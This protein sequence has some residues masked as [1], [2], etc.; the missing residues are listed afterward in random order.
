MDLIANCSW[1]IV[2]PDW[3]SVEPSSGTGSVSVILRAESN[4]GRERSG[5]LTVTGGDA[6]TEVALYQDGVDFSVDQK[7]F[8]F[9]SD[10]NPMEFT[11]ISKYDWSITMHNEA[12]WVTADP[13]SGNAGETRVRLTPSPITDRTPRNRTYLTVNYNKSF[14]NL[15]VSQD[16]PNFPPAAPELIAPAMGDTDVKINA[17][18]SWNASADPD[19]DAVKYRL[20]L[21]PD[22]GS[23]WTTDETSMLKMRPSRLLSPDTRYLWKVQA[24]DEFGGVGESDVWTFETGDGGG[25]TDGE[26][27]LYMEEK[28]KAGK[29]VHLIFM[30]DGYIAEDYAAGAAFDKDV[31]AAVDA[32][33][34]I[35]PYAS[36]KDYFRVS[37]VA[38][39][40][41]EREATVLEGMSMGPKTPQ[42]R[43]TAFESV[44]QGGNTTGVSCNYGKVYEYALTVPG[45][46]ESVLNEAAIFLLINI[47]AYAGTCLI[48][49]GGRSI[50][51]CPMSKGYYSS[52]VIH[53]GGGHG[54]GR[55]MDEYRYYQDRLPQDQ[56]DLIQLWR[57]YEPYFA[58][59]I[60][61]VGDRE[62]V[63]WAH[64]F[65]RSGYEAV[66]MFEGAYYYD[67][68]VWR[69]EERSCMEDNRAYYNAPSREAIVRRIMSSS[70]STFNMESFVQKDYI[71]ADPT[72]RASNYVEISVPL[73][74]PVLIGF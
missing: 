35:E 60:D 54:F 66:D 61:V 67:F 50:A 58:N 7:A 28:A 63:H 34:S 22:E 53:E 23:T 41:Q 49:A 15:V 40:S 11:I 44:L 1:T 47:D 52:I 3:V 6:V 42:Q 24:I 10:G 14:V 71:K 51:M 36:Y 19:G 13:S 17:Y 18:F 16:L 69:P 45:V 30:G 72:T 37:T 59:N 25:Y 2:A 62:K 64:Y 74:P 73:A 38:V 32:L 26:V 56:K 48:E 70:G 8:H 4:K 20:M 55:L 46:D 29:P 65:Q 43:I 5:V 33:F 68:G 21:S 27:S 39:Y 12:S 31:E 9:N 57:R